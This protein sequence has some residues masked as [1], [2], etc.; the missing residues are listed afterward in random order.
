[1]Y[2][3]TTIKSKYNIKNSTGNNEIIKSIIRLKM[4]KKDPKFD[5][6]KQLIL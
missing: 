2:K 4:E 3:V 1:M 5:L 6:Q